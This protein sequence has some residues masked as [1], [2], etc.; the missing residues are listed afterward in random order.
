[1]RPLEILLVED[2]PA[3]VVL[4]RE[5]LKATTIKHHLHTVVD[6]E[7]ASDFIRRQGRFE[8]APRPDLILLDLNLHAGVVMKS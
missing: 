8:G 5:G 6:G 2:N 4:V 7:E 3:D 1:V